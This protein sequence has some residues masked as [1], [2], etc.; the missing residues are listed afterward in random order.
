MAELRW[1]W[2]GSNTVVEAD[3]DGDGHADLHVTLT[4]RHSLS[5]DDFAL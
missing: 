5:A 4:G 3:I 2:S 1:F